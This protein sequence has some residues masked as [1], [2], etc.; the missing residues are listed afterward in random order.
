MLQKLTFRCRRSCI[1]SRSDRLHNRHVYDSYLIY[2]H[3]WKPIGES[4]GR[5]PYPNCATCEDKI[6]IG[7]LELCSVNEC[8]LSLTR[9]I[10]QTNT[11]RTGDTTHT[12][13]TKHRPHWT[14]HT[15][16]TTHT[17][18]T[19]HRPHWT[20]HTGDTTHTQLTKHRP[21]WTNH[22]G[23]TTHTQLTKRR[24]HSWTNHTGD[25]T[26]TQLTKPQPHSWTNHTGDTTH[27]QLTKPQPHSWTNHTGDTTR[28]QLTKPNA[29]PSYQSLTLL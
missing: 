10:T 17:Q 29:Q 2:F 18:L 4:H 26:H 15:G 5:G 22:T 9:S 8:W 23:D 25:T 19:K 14:N 11:D 3:I 16:D 27:T 13:L 7:S 24:P 1:Y 28:T 20:N 12:Q 21:H 6:V